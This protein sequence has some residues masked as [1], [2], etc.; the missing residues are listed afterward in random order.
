MAGKPAENRENP[1]DSI[2]SLS[3]ERAIEEL[4]QIID[5]IETGQIGLEESL[6]AYERGVRLQEHCQQIL[7]TTEQR[8]QELSLRAT[9][10]ART[11]ANAD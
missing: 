7:S 5:R 4:Q 9:P 6:K 2:E 1:Q 8:V 3:Y 11:S 10:R